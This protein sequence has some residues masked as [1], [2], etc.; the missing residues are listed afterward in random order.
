MS[1]SETDRPLSAI[2][3]V[4]VRIGAFAA[5]LLSGLAGG[6][7][8]Y[9]LVELQCDGDCAIPTGI[10]LL[11]G[12]VTAAGGMA[13]VAVLVMRALGEWREVNDRERAGHSSNT[14]W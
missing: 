7:I 9:S 2:P 8:G 1:S 11:V 14:S 12:A 5:I 6:L 3:S 13:I 4:G 10:G